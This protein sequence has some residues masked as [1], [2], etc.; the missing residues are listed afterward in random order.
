VK[1]KNVDVKNEKRY[2]LPTPAPAADATGPISNGQK[3][4]GMQSS[5]SNR[6]EE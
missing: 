5:K 4:D 6:G 1:E 2:D 3:S